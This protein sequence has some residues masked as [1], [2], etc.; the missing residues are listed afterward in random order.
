[1]FV[2]GSGPYLQFLNPYS[3]NGPEL[4]Q[5]VLF[6]VD[7]GPANLDLIE[8]MPDR[9]P[10]LQKTSKLVLRPRPVERR[11]TVSV[12]RL[13][14][15]RGG[16][17]SLHVR[18]TNP[19]GSPTVAA[20]LKFGD[21]LEWRTLSTDATAEGVYETDWTLVAP[22]GD[23]GEEHETAI[24]L[25]SRLGLG[26]GFLIAGVG[27]GASEEVARANPSV[28]QIFPYRIDGS[29]VELLLPAEKTRQVTVAG[30]RTWRLAKSPPELDVTAT[31]D[32]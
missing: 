16:S 5:R 10:Y 29:A 3:A 32:P 31:A 27:F 2:S 15:Q 21:H 30:R 28:R 25:T 4:D 24:P 18:I 26:R 9:T 7:R 14:V 22:N 11:P 6:A 12:T 20:Y 23:G 13:D 19:R 17:V 1:M 8:A